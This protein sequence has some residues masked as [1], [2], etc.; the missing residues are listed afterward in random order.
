[1]TYV[2]NIYVTKYFQVTDSEYISRISGFL[3]S[4]KL[5]NIS[6]FFKKD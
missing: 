2:I 5:G 6:C 4:G 3:S 1:M